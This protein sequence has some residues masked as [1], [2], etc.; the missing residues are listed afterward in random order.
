M[1]ADILSTLAARLRVARAWRDISQEDAG[2]ENG[3]SRQTWNGY[4]KGRIP[5]EAVSDLE[6]WAAKHSPMRDAEHAHAF[7]MLDAAERVSRTVAD[8]VH[9]ARR[10]LGD[11]MLSVSAPAAA[12]REGPEEAAAL[13]AA[14]TP[15]PPT[16]GRRQAEG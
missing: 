16:R 15:R 14:G 9:D 5:T 12:A 6:A 7:G 1:T 10:R 4:E 3:V 8:V 13:T 2:A 11:P